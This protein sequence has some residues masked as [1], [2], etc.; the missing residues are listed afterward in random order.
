M[1]RNIAVNKEDKNQ[2]NMAS[3]WKKYLTEQR[4]MNLK[5]NR[6]R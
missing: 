6:G 4:E 3:G 5:S 2:G 1:G